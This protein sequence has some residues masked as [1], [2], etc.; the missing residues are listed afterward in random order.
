MVARLATRRVAARPTIAHNNICGRTILDAV[1]ISTLRGQWSDERPIYKPFLE[2]QGK[3]NV[4]V[5][6]W[7]SG[8]FEGGWCGE[9]YA[10]ERVVSFDFLKQTIGQTLVEVKHTQRK[11]EEDGRCVVQ[12]KME[13]K[14]ELLPPFGSSYRGTPRC[15]EP[16][17]LICTR[18]S[19][20][21]LGFPYADCFAVHV[22]HVASRDGGGNDLTI[23]IG[24]HVEFLKSCLFEKK[25]RVRMQ[26]FF[27]W[28]PFLPFFFFFAAF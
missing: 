11:R 20:A 13:M 22:R 7:Q 27:S 18:D 25:I 23:Q 6:P 2:G 12:I 28:H 21:F 14:G 4:T 17:R 15:A 8:T 19:P 3:N 9:T 10:E 24:M 5:L 1:C 26:Y 16:V